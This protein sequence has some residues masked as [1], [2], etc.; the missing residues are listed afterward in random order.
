MHDLVIISID[1]GMNTRH[2]LSWRCV[3]A[4]SAYIIRIKECCNLYSCTPQIQE[5]L[6]TLA[7]HDQCVGA[8]GDCFLQNQNTPPDEYSNST[9]FVRRRKR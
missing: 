7:G 8:S 1:S 2:P 6:D 9:Q 4:V 3:A 5:T